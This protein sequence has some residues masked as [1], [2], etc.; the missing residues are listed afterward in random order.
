MSHLPRGRL[1]LTLLGFLA[2][3]SFQVRNLTA[4]DAPA[5]VELPEHF[6][7]FRDRLTGATLVGHFTVGN[8]VA[9]AKLHAERYEIRSVKKVGDGDFWLIQARIQYG[10]KDV[11][12]PVPVEVKWAEKTPVITLDNVTIPGLGTV[13]ARVLF[14]G[15][16]Y[17]GTWRHDDVVGHMF[18]I[19]VEKRKG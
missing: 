1:C 12:V 13:G 3:T 16:R 11:T 14:E 15:N 4:Q 2:T 18:G 8:E 5:K 10:D 17:A 7:E 19:V 6:A 9:E